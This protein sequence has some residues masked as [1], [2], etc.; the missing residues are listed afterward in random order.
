RFRGDVVDYAVDAA[1]LVDDAGGGRAQ[2]FV[3]EGIGVRRH[4]VGG[5]YGAQGEHVI[6]G[7]AVAHH[8]DAA[9]RQQHR[10]GLPNGI[11]QTGAAD[12]VEIDRVRLAQY[13]E[14]VAR[15]RAGHADR[16][17]GAGERMPPDEA[18]RQAEFTAEL[19]HLVLEQFAQRLDQ[20]QLHPRRQAA[21]IVMRLD[22]DARPAGETHRLNDV[23]IE[24]ALRQ[25]IGPA[26]FFRFLVEH[27]DEGSADDLALLFGVFDS[28]ELAKEQIARVAMHQRNVVVAA[29]QFDDFLGFTLPQQAVID[30]DAG[31]LVADR[32]VQQH[33]RD[34]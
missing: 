18:L 14:L 27:V 1:H 30:E 13:F 11:I 21:D 25:E 5:G 22:G 19:A 33:R 20:F 8:A 31:E 4:A 26:E 9:H 23:G 28:G 7:A 6:V 3:A 32:L 34:R 15:N 12:L 2:K 10:E 16:E 29:E 24:R 17:A